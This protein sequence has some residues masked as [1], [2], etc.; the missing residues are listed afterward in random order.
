[1][2][3]DLLKVRPDN[4]LLRSRSISRVLGVITDT[5]PEIRVD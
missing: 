4:S 3:F 5:F 2:G 1:L